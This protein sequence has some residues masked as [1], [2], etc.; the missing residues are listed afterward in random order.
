[1]ALARHDGWGRLSYEAEV[2]GVA[3]ANFIDRAAPAPETPFEDVRR[4]SLDSLIDEG[5]LPLPNH[6]KIDVDGNEAE[7]VAG[8]AKM[9]DDP[10]LRSIRLE[11]KSASPNRR[12]FVAYL[13]DMGF[14][15]SVA[16]DP[17]NLLFERM[18]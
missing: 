5:T 2:A 12:A 7:V 11:V 3:N 1:M 15:V 9:L 4:R 10:W 13:T 8:M 6:I 18:G 17:K 16:V 14:R